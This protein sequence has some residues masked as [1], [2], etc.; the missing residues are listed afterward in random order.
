MIAITEPEDRASNEPVEPRG[1]PDPLPIR[2]K[3]PKATRRLNRRTVIILTTLVALVVMFSLLQAFAPR[4]PAED[5]QTRAVTS[6][7]APSDALSGL[8]QDYSDIKPDTP[9]LAAPLHGELGATVLAHNRNIEARAASVQGG[10]VAQLSEEEKALEAARLLTLKRAADARSAEVFFAGQPVG[11]QS[12][13]S[14]TALASGGNGGRDDIINPQRNPARDDDNRQ[15]DKAGFL[16]DTRQDNPYLPALLSKPVSAYQ[17]MAGTII[18]GLLLTGINSDLPGQIVGQVSQNVFDTVTGRHLL[19]PQGTRI[20][21]HYDSRVTYGQ[22]R[23]LIVWAR[24]ILP[25]GSSISLEGMPGVD[26]SG[27]AGLN[28]QVDNHYGRLLG[29]VVLGSLLGA[30]GQLSQGSTN[31]DNPTFAQ[32]AAQGAA[33]NINQTGQ[34]LTRKNLSVQPTLGIRPGFRFNVFVTRDVVLQPYQE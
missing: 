22:E 34:Q 9:K 11:L 33:Q 25:N 20:I 17:V 18:P 27:Y 14:S 10:Q 24:L 29:G 30:A 16:N 8:P 7:P 5:E 1:T 28:D 19:I 32:L 23:V 26:L 13:P 2:G 15:D 4:R 3:K 6:T 31:T 12:A 21:G